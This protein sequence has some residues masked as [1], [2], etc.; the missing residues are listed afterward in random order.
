MENNTIRTN[1]S[2]RTWDHLVSSFTKIR[3]KELICLQKHGLTMNQ[4][5]VLNVLYHKGNQNIGSITKL[6]MSTPGNITV[7]IKNLKRDKLITSIQDKSDKRASVLSITNS[8][9]KILD[10]L[11]D[12]HENELAQNFEVMN[13][14]ELDTLFSLLRK[15][16]TS[17]Q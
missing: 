15:L 7:V 8:G 1:K 5:Q 14:A 6:I 12:N 10:G 16:Q 2:V 11:F 13:D 3:S 9:K 17:Q 4:Y